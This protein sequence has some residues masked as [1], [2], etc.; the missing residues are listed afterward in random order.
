[1]SKTDGGPQQAMHPQPTAIDLFSG[2]GGAS[3][4]LVRAGFNLRLSVDLHPMYGE[5]H[6]ANLPGQFLAADLKELDAEKIANTAAIKVD[7]LDVLFAGPPCQGFSMLG[8]RVIWDERNNLFKEVL[9]VGAALRPK[10]IVIENVPGLVTLANGAYLRAILEGL[11][12]I[13]YEASCAELLAAAYGAPQMRWRLIIV[14]WREDLGIP[15]G[16]GFPQPTHGSSPIGHLLPNCSILPE[17]LRGFVTAREALG[18]LPAIEAGGQSDVYRGNPESAYQKTMRQGLTTELYNH[19]AA[20]LS[21]VNLERLA[22]LKPGQDW[23]D[24]PYDLLPPGMQRAKRK[25]HTRRYR[26]MT[27]DGIPRSVVTRFRDP[28][29]G[30]YTHPEQDRTISIREAAR[31]QGFPDNFIFHGTRSSQYEQVGNAVPVPLAEAIAAEVRRCLSGELGERLD[32]PF[33][34]R[35]VPLIGSHGELIEQA[36]LNF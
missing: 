12:K 16:Y 3:L 17:E 26:R 18:D 8:S 25:D 29:T 27:W 34:R 21:A 20:A 30:E 23:R 6:A 7:E 15:H 28:K 31:L 1:M 36:M 33:S 5:T 22:L 13:G 14:A 11:K 4:G 2:A 9:R 19:Y 24:L 10:A 32:K 35:P